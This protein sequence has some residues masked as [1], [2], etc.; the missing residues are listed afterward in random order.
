MKKMWKLPTIQSLS[1]ANTA[2]GPSPAAL[3][4][5]SGTGVPQGPQDSSGLCTISVSPPPCPVFP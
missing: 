5:L 4:G 2:T 3:E 1:I